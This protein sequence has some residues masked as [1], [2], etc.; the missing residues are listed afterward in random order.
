MHSFTPLLVVVL[1]ALTVPLALTR[2]RRIQLPIVVGEI[3]AGIVVGRS[4]FGLVAHEDPLLKLLA[5][6]GFVFLM[7]LSGMEVDFSLLGAARAAHRTN[8]QRRWDP[9]TLGLLSFAMTL[10]LSAFAGYG[11][12]RLGLVRNPWMMALILSTTSLGIVVPVLKE[13]GLSSGRYGQTL[14]IA[15][16]IADFVTMLF[17]TILVAT[18]SGGTAARILY[19]VML[20][21]AVF[22]FY[23]LGIVVNRIKAV[24]QTLDELSHAAAQIKVRAAFAL[25]LVV[26]ALSDALGAEMILGAFMAGIIVSLLR[27]PQDTALAHQLEGIGFGFFIPIF[28]IM[29]GVQ[30]NLPALFGSRETLWLLP[31]LLGAAVLIKLVSGLVFRLGFGWREAL[32]A[33]VLLSARLSLIIAAAAIGSELGIISESVNA[34][35][36]LVAIVTVTAAPP[37]FLRLVPSR[38]RAKARPI[39]VAGAGELGLQVAEQLRGHREQVIV[40]DADAER[41][42]RARQHGFDAV[43]A[44]AD[45]PDPALAPYLDRAQTIVCTYNDGD[46]SYR[47]CQFVRANYGI[48]HIVTQ[49]TDPREL[50]RFQQLGVTTMNAAIDRAALL[51]L[52]ARNPAAYALLSRTDENTEI[53][54]IALRSSEQA[55]KLVRELK[56]PGDVLLVAVRRGGELLVPHGN[57]RLDLGDRLTLVGSRD[58]IE[59]ARWIFM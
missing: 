46:L 40:V 17:I 20:F 54:E 48:D 13:A 36:I 18:L 16:L 1:L 19:V 8:P 5:E 21:G 43:Q 47:I 50:P 39:I 44:Q 52:L 26:V 4:G 53:R 27:D 12:W 33:G 3:L 37:V 28:F 51:V 23:R 7:F 59:Q 45:Q 15:A 24:R 56:L 6:L 57:T 10:L 32:G 9:I 25:M 11:M 31:L 34:A 41:V 22:L 35:I 58:S 29:V 49:V 30:F 38:D 14:L 42:Q 55:D 2:L